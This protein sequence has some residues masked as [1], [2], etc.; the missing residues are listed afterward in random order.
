MRRRAGASRPS[1][2]PGATPRS[3][4]IETFHLGGLPVGTQ[5][6][7]LVADVVH[8]MRHEMKHTAA[9]GTAPVHLAHAS[10]ANGV[11]RHIRGVGTREQARPQA[12]PG[13]AGVGQPPGT[14]GGREIRISTHESDVRYKTGHS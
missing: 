13:R 5:G 9:A 6:D 1:R 10:Q 2:R 14:T 7:S 11:E 12:R 3:R 4:L 8:D